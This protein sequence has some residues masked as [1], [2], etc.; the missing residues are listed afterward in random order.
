M[1]EEE[2]NT[3]LLDYTDPEKFFNDYIRD[4][5][6]VISDLSEEEFKTLERNKDFLLAKSKKIYNLS[7]K[8]GWECVKT[9]CKLFVDS[10][11]QASA[12][13]IAKQFGFNFVD[14]F[15]CK[16]DVFNEIVDRIGVYMR[17]GVPP[18]DAV[19]LMLVDYAN[20]RIFTADLNLWLKFWSINKIINLYKT[21]ENHNVNN[22]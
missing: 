8:P 7:N 5:H 13:E 20:G 14:G 15:V 6:R 3:T 2:K 16:D 21:K 17:S 4:N 10:L 18:K 12:E 11:H 9:V 22:E 19:C 1:A